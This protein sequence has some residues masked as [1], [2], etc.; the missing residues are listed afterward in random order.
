V[1]PEDIEK[2]F[3]NVMNEEIVGTNV[4]LKILAH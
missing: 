3:K 1:N 2:D 4:K